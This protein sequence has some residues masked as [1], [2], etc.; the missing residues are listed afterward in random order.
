MEWNDDDDVHKTKEIDFLAIF[1]IRQ[2]C[3]NCSTIENEA[4]PLSPSVRQLT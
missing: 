4:K 1:P 2:F 3:K